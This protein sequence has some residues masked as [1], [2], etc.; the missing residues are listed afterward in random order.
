MAAE[1]TREMAALAWMQVEE[2]MA[3]LQREIAAAE[4]R[5]QVAEARAETAEQELAECEAEEEKCDE[6]FQAALIDLAAATAKADALEVTVQS[7]RAARE[8]AERRCDEMMAKLKDQPTINVQPA[9]VAPSKA[10]QM[11]GWEVKINRDGA[12]NML[13]FQITPKKG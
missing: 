5:A 9:P 3:T 10:V 11:A 2:R 4:A 8:A 6:Q 12:D 1:S 13:G 7:E